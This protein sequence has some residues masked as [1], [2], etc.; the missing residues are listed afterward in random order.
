MQLG[1]RIVLDGD[2]DP[3]L[4]FHVDEHVLDQRRAVGQEDVV[5]VGATPAWTQPHPASLGDRDS[6]DGHRV[7]WRLAMR[8]Q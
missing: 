4:V 5:S 3:V 6:V 7:W 2:G 1:A 8:S